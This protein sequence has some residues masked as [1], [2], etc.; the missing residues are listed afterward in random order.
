MG[1]RTRRESRGGYL[2][3]SG[4]RGAQAARTD[5]GVAG[6]GAACQAA[7]VLCVHRYQQLR[8]PL[9]RRTF[10]Y[11]NARFFKEHGI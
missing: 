10:E 7:R 9:L 4:G 11:N 5:R 3:A 2:T 1:S 8:E 6:T